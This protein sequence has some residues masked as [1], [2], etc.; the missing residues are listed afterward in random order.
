M[1]PT[2]S[3][4]QWEDKLEQY[5]FAFKRSYCTEDAYNIFIAVFQACK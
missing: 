2:Y 4:R 1:L 5:L 3:Y